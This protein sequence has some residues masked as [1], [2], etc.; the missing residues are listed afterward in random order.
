MVNYFGWWRECESSVLL[1]SY[2]CTSSKSR[3]ETFLVTVKTG[4]INQWLMGNTLR[5]IYNTKIV[6]MHVNMLNGCVK[7]LN[8]LS[9]NRK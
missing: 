9:M 8:V 4:K 7:S 3:F 1:D 6:L 2:S 5:S